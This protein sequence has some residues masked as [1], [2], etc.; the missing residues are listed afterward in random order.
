MGRR[1]VVLAPLALA[2]CVVGPHYA[3]PP[4]VA[5]QA[6][7]HFVRAGD[8]AVAAPAVAPWWRSL[9]DP[10]LDALIARALANNPDVAVA[11]A[12]LRQARA[13]LGLEKAN[14]LPKTNATALYAHA[15]LPGVNLGQSGSGG[16]G[17]STTDLNLYNVGF[18]ASWEIDL[19]GGE[20]HKLEAARATAEAAQADSA[21]AE[22]SLSAEVAKAY[23]A[24]RDRQ[25]RIALNARSV[26]MEEQMLALTRQRYAAGTASHLDVARLDTDLANTRADAVPLNAD[27]DAYLDELATL[28]GDP[29]GALDAALGPPRPVPLPPPVLAIGDPAALI[30][31]RPDIRSAERTLAADT[32][33]IGVAEAA[34]FP[35]LSFMGIIGI[36]GTKP[37]DLTK[38]DDFTL[39]AAPQLSWS[40][41]DFG[42]SKAQVEKAR[43]VRDEAEAQYRSK[44]LA[45]LRDA[46]DSL[47]R[48]RYR[49]V[50]VAT[51]ARAKASADDAARLSA[52]R[53]QAGTTTL[54]DLLDIQ[55]QQIAAEQALS[56]A[57][58]QL[59]T[60]YVAIQ[61]AMGFGWK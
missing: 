29:P 20:R 47:S 24:L 2:G 45:A 7:D 58:A 28:T 17:G 44:L 11:Q 27:R 40:F 19:F 16:N 52:Q 4:Q 8:L 55:R 15:H 53:Y 6:A 41:L 49:R 37:S 30:R 10:T 56:T 34:R 35:R 48:F 26:A 32:A 50:T 14:A 59:T 12:R 5:P 51:L 42:R 57:E 60:D 36:G 22:V 13:A 3:G 23:V 46:E 1:L 43:A 25:R 9:D 38:L 39:L 18:D 31:R 21:D 54:I 61:K 33:R